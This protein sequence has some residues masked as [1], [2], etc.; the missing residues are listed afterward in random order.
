LGGKGPRFNGVDQP[1]PNQGGSRVANQQ[2]VVTEKGGD[3]QSLG[4]TP[5]TK[6]KKGNADWN[7][8]A[9]EPKK[10]EIKGGG[11]LTANISIPQEKS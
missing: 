4:R 8:R 9:W 3:Y 7:K 10:D 1:I 5:S 11:G 2:R 6:K